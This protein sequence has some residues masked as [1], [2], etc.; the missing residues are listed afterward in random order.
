M[1]REVREAALQMMG[2]YD[3]DAPLLRRTFDTTIRLAAVG[4]AVSVACTVLGLV[5][6]L[7]TKA[8]VLHGVE[9]TLYIVGAAIVLVTGV[10][11]GTGRR[12][13]RVLRTGGEPAARLP[14]QYMLVGLAVIGVAIA[15]ESLAG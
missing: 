11:G 12:N 1:R 6:G 10:S 14:W 5:I 9:D 7:A 3:P 2:R 13:F 8:T 4:V 15:I